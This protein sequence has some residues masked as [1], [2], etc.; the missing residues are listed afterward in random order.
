MFKDIF[1]IALNTLRMHK[2]RSF[3]TMLGIII[4]IMVIILMQAA[5][6]GLRKEI[7]TEIDKLG[8][9]SFVVSKMPAFQH[10]ND[11]EKYEK[12][13]NLTA[14]LIP[15]IKKDC[16]DITG[17][18]PI[19]ENWNEEI[20]YK[21]K[22]TDRKAI[23]IGASDGWLE[24]SGYEIGE[25]R[26]FS[27][28]DY[29]FRQNYVVIGT[30][31]SD[32]LFDGAS[33]V[34]RYV[35]IE[36]K[37]FLVIG[38]FVSKGTKFNY[39]QDI[40][41]C[42]SDFHY[43]KLYGKS[44]NIDMLVQ[45]VS[46]QKLS[47]AKDQ[48]IMSLRRQ[49]N[50]KADDENDFEITTKDEITDK[51]NGI[52][53]VIYLVALSIGGMSLLV[54]SIGIMNM[55]LVS[56]TERTNE[57]GIRRSLGANKVNIITQFLIESVLLSLTGGTAGIIIGISVSKIISAVSS[58]STFAPLWTIATAFTVS[59]LIGISAGIYPALKASN[60]NPIDALRQ[61]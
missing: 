46:T 8:S 18:I 47:A 55:M 45:A 2:L 39:D 48:V 22:K 36:N 54:G 50:L 61:E 32:R 12:R 5:I 42:I 13:T 6:E 1:I 26:F 35:L 38:E 21:N 4:G 33:P 57:I 37:K 56:I 15:L 27:E 20:T 28:N 58:Y 14:D 51:M 24:I 10:G 34:G 9:A 30:T 44:R 31:I 52:I 17:I 43:E 49:R 7:S 60:L 53:A 59:L 29:L 40:I 23:I 3:L 19:M 41:A 11:W 16:P 25:G